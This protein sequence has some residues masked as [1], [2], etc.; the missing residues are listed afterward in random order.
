MGLHEAVHGTKPVQPEGPLRLH[1]RSDLLNSSKE[2]M[3]AQRRPEIRTFVI[4][5]AGI[6]LI[7]RVSNLLVPGGGSLREGCRVDKFGNVTNEF[8]SKID[9][10]TQKVRCEITLP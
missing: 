6:E 4:Y 9:S 3:H 5:T 7:I 8:Q 1:F 10:G 2:N